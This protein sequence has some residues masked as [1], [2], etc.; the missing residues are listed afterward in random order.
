MCV[1]G[2]PVVCARDMCSGLA[3]SGAHGLIAIEAP[4]AMPH[5]THSV[6][7]TAT[8]KATTTTPTTTKGKWRDPKNSPHHS[9]N[10]CSEKKYVCPGFNNINIYNW[11]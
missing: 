7:Y 2:C 11:S 1:P 10:C 8:T 4:G 6:H 5:R 3:V 9:P